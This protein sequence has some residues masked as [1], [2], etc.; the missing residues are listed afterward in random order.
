[1]RIEQRVFRDNSFLIFVMENDE[2]SRL[3]D[4]WGRPDS[5]VTFADRHDF[6]K[7]FRRHFGFALDLET[8]ELFS[9]VKPF[10]GT[11]QLS[12]GYGEWYLRVPAKIHEEEVKLVA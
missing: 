9:E 10:I 7:L 2:E 6:A 12:D 11:L 4:E 8:G 1:M 3:L 5:A